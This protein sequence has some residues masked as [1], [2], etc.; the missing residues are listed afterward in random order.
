MAN[1]IITLTSD[2]GAADGF[3]A[4]MKAAILSRVSDVTL[5]DVTHDV[6]PQDVAHASFVLGT[7]AGRFPAGT[8]HCAVVDP[9][10]GSERA[11][12]V[13]TGPGG[14]VFAGPD[15]GIFTHA[16]SPASGVAPGSSHDRPFLAPYR[17]PVPD[18]WQAWAVDVTAMDPGKVSRT[19]HGRDVF[20]PV[21]ARLAGG[22]SP[23]DLGE[24]VG[25]VTLLNL[26]GP[27]KHDDGLV[28]HVQYVDGFGN[29]ATDI[30]SD[31]VPSG[32]FHAQAGNRALS[33]IS[34]SYASAQGAGCIVASHGFLEIF[35]TGGSAAEELGLSVGD[36]VAIRV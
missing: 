7:V 25:E 32:H 16:M 10:V 20:A 12:I 24:E 5:V 36:E 8:V 13:A 27:R 4:A 2:F 35:V 21:A 11:A 3:P 9:G 23:A 18:G 19:F 29:A 31:A 33:G 30:P 6:P 22:A 26:P 17:V 34:E 14:Q 15:N 28:G 1:P